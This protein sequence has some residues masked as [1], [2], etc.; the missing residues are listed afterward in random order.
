MKDYGV[1]ILR[2]AVGITYVMHAYLALFRFT[3]AGT[4]A[5]MASLG[6]PAPVVM[7]W[8]TI[9][10]HGLGGIMLILGLAT[11]WAA[12]A[13]AVIIA[14]AL[15]MVHLPQGFFLKVMAGGQRVGGFEF[16]LLLFAATVALT[17]TGGGA[18]VVTRK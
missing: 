5:F 6:L 2:L 13:N 10:V 1:T 11:R 17:L 18:L 12:L 9:I 3:P 7:A 4:A 14:G 8:I 16:V 15:V